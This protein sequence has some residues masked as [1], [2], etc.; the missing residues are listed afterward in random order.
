[1]SDGVCPPWSSYVFAPYCNHASYL[2]RQS[3]NKEEKRQYK[4]VVIKPTCTCTCMV[5]TCT[6]RVVCCTVVHAHTRTCSVCIDGMQ[7]MCFQ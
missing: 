2:L 6:C 4:E 3:T 1:M 5:C 7:T